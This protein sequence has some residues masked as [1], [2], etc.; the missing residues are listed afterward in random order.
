MV[1][2][3]LKL[4]G[5]RTKTYLLSQTLEKSMQRAKD[6]RAGLSPAMG[7][8][9]IH[10][11]CSSGAPTS[12]LL[13][14]FNAGRTHLLHELVCISSIICVVVQIVNHL[15]PEMRGIFGNLWGKKEFLRDLG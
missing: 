12:L 15:K 4:Y 10:Q 13:A 3:S 7:T 6:L 8:T 11:S 1:T 14:E 5:S 2:V 9:S